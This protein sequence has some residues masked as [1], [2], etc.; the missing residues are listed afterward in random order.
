MN[1]ED[2]RFL[3]S[4]LIQAIPTVLSLALIAMF[5]FLEMRK[6]II[7]IQRKHL[8][9]IFIIL[10]FVSGIIIADV[11]VLANL[12]YYVNNLQSTVWLMT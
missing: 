10:A 5:A 9:W 8:P 12:E 6:K 11:M 3:L 4:A 7:D 2:I 1:I